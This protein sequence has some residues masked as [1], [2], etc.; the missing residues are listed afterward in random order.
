MARSPR[1]RKEKIMTLA[2]FFTNQKIVLSSTAQ[3]G[4]FRGLVGLEAKAKDLTIEAKAKD[5]TI[6]AKAKDFKMCS[7]GRLRGLPL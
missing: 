7:R 5:L 6:E 1:R 2:H 4:H 3:T